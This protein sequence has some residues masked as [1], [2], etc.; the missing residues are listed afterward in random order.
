[1]VT[2]NIIEYE[3]KAKVIV[4]HSKNLILSALLLVFGLSASVSAYAFEWDMENALQKIQQS[5][6]SSSCGLVDSGLNECNGF[7][8]N[9]SKMDKKRKVKTS[10]ILKVLIDGF[11]VTKIKLNYLS[12][13]KPGK[14][15][16]FGIRQLQKKKFSRFN[17]NIFYQGAGVRMR[18]ENDEL[19]FMLK[20]SPGKIDSN[21]VYTGVSVRF[22][23]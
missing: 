20:K 3:V 2:D 12:R 10:D 17:L 13:N 21:E 16:L 7:F 8:S 9:K 19:T 11:V 6:V 14:S 23:W 15:K 4:A 1:M 22:R 5:S 18:A